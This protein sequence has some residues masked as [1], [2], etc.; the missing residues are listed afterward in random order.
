[1]A[2][3]NLQIIDTAL[4]LGQLPANTTYRALARR[5]YNLFIT[6]EADY[7]YPFYRKASAPVNFVAGQK[8]YP[9]PADYLWSE[10]VYLYDFTSASRGA[11]INI[12]NPWKFDQF[13]VGSVSGTPLVCSIDVEGKNLLFNSAPNSSDKGFVL[14][15]FRAP[16]EIN[17][18]GNDDSNYPDFPNMKLLINGIL[19][20][21]FKY[22]DEERYQQQKQE[23]D[24]LRK[25]FKGTIED[26][27]DNSIINLGN[28]FIAGSR[29]RRGGGNFG[30]GQ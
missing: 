27:N 18:D 20:W 26:F 2:Q 5:Y 13:Q 16:N 4:S 17:E 30:W 28:N 22:N 14:T 15:Y 8:A 23:V 12:I 21:L 7:R 11:K 25:D 10:N 24:S 3:T 1:M 6:D 29:P 19:E 9:L